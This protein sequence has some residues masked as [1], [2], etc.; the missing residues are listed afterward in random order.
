[1]GVRKT[2]EG[3][4]GMIRKIRM[5]ASN[6]ASATDGFSRTLLIAVSAPDPVGTPDCEMSGPRAVRI[7][8]LD[9]GMKSADIAVLMGTIYGLLDTIEDDYTR[10]FGEGFRERVD[11]ARGCYGHAVG[12]VF[13]PVEPSKSRPWRRSAPGPQGADL[14]LRIADQG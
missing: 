5:L 4:D 1:M 13:V 9:S 8:T 12:V 7:Q 6:C 2:F 10:E 3:R 11:T 14:T